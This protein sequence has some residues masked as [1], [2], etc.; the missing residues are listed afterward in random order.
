M[1]RVDVERRVARYPI[2]IEHGLT[3]QLGTAD[4]AVAGPP[5][6]SSSS[7]ARSCGSCT[8]RRSAKAVPKTEPILLPDGEKYKQLAT[9]SRAYESLIK[10]EADRGAG[11]IAV[12]GGVIGDMA[13]FVAATYLRGIKL[14]Q[15]PTTLLAQVDSAIGGKV[16]VNHPLGKN[17]IGAFHQPSLVA[18]D[19]ALLETLPRREFRAGLYEVIKYGMTSSRDLFDR[20]DRDMDAIFARK[21]DALVPIIGESCSI[22]AAV[23][24]L[25]ERESGPRRMLNFG[26]TAGH[27]LEAVTKYKRFRHGEAIAYGM[28]VAA[29]I[30]RRA[31]RDARTPTA[32]RSAKMIMKLGPLPPVGDLST[33]EV[34]EAMRHDKKVVNG[35][36]HYVLCTGIGSWTT[37]TD[38]TEAELGKALRQIGLEEVTTS[39]VRNLRRSRI[40]SASPAA[41]CMGL[42]DIRGPAFVAAW[43]PSAPARFFSFPPPI[44][45]RRETS[46]SDPDKSNVAQGL[47]GS[48][49]TAGACSDRF[50]WRAWMVSLSER[51]TA[52]SMQ[53]CSSRTLPGQRYFCSSS[54]ADGASDDRLLHVAA[55]PLDE[56]ARENRNVLRPFAQRRNRDR[57]HRQAEIQVFAELPRRHAGAQRLVRGGDDPHVDVQRLRSADALESALF[58]RAQDLGLQAEREIADLVEKQRAAMGELELAGLARDRAGE[59]ALSR[60][61]TARSRAD[62]PES[63][64]S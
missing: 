53:F 52:R 59:R 26:H 49:W 33:R 58:E 38:V 29:E 63:R 12:G 13:G 55:E 61:R 35:T 32:R 21:A 19:P 31:R 48:G 27:A 60:G 3:A 24:G 25:D 14:I 23:V 18:I 22:K 28:L 57:K 43:P 40:P 17:L 34:L 7:P 6:V 45:A 4:R 1:L 51:M 44:C 41:S 56:V 20:I 46:A 36:L 39:D 15:V 2:Y 5:R 16:G 62:C 47:G 9:A 11:I 8:G 50:R 10:L 42:P 37:V 30:A 54:I 64:R